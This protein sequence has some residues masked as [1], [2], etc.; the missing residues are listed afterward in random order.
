M[1]RTSSIHDAEFGAAMTLS[2]ARWESSALFFRLN[3][4]VFEREIVIKPFE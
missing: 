2:A 3:G 4:E 1:A